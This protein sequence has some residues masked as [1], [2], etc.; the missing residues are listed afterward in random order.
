MSKASATILFAITL[1]FGQASCPHAQT[2]SVSVS[3]LGNI[4]TVVSAATGTTTFRVDDNLGTVTT[5]SGSA[6][7]MTTGTISPMVASVTC[8]GTYTQ[9]NKLVTISIASAGT[10]T[11]RAG[12]LTNF[13]ATAGTASFN[14][15]PS[16]TNPTTFKLNAIARNSTV[17]FYVGYDFPIKADDSGTPTGT[18][19]SQ[20][21]VVAS[22]TGA[23][24][25]TGSGTASATVLR[26]ITLTNSATLSFGRLVLPAS[27][28]QTVTLSPAV[29]SV[30]LS[31]TGSGGTALASPAA[32]LASFSVAGEGGQSFTLTVPASFTLNG[33]SGSAPITIT[34]L[35]S[36]GGA[37]TLSGTIGS[38]GSFGF[39]IG[40]SFPMAS[41]TQAGGYS[42]TF[43]TTV[44]YN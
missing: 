19:S 39:T 25:G 24:T 41:S 35:P 11:N 18:S 37:Q 14:T 38:S 10:P 8:S 30:K 40:G 1:A 17:T 13:T 5:V 29:P 9:C 36:A 31:G 22:A 44:Q 4:G 15:T 6:T 21:S 43:S 16:G 32:T 2:Y 28:T 20:L 27:G 33:P 7:R 42:G 12:A 3:P 26:S 34:T 23:T